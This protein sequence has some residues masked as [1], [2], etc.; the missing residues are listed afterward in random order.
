MHAYGVVGLLQPI[1]Q[2]VVEFHG[3][4]SDRYI[5]A[6]RRL[7]PFFHVAH[8]HYNNY[9]CDPALKPFP[10]SAYE[11]LFVSKKLGVLDPSRRGGGTSALDAPNNPNAPDC[12]VKY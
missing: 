8:V 10:A 7:A 4:A 9:S 5:A 2:L 6:V 3:V 12:Q 1:D 11:V